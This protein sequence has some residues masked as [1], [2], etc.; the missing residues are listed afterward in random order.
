[1]SQPANPA[2]AQVLREIAGVLN[3][4]LER[5]AIQDWAVYGSVPYGLWTAPFSLGNT[6]IFVSVLP[7]PV[8][9]QLDK[10]GK[11]VASE[12]TTLSVDLTNSI[13][14]IRPAPRTAFYEEACSRLARINY[15][16]LQINVVRPEYLLF[17][18]LRTWRKEPEWGSMTR[19]ERGCCGLWRTKARRKGW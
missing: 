3:A 11:E 18:A 9:P 8:G 7:G 2:Q 1:M 17:M 15:M 16:G 13:V 4:P 6:D 14:K 5:G 19:R 10:M 12:A